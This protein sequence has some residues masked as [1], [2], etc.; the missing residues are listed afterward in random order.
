MARKIV[1]AMGWY[2]DITTFWDEE[3]DSA[4]LAI[5]GEMLQQGYIFSILQDGALQQ[6]ATTQ[7]ITDR[8]VVMP[9][10]SFSRAVQNGLMGLGGVR[11]VSDQ[12]V[13]GE[14]ARDAA[15]VLAHD[16]VATPPMKG[17]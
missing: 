9:T 5:I 14:I 10:D 17:G 16:T 1:L 7:Q 8:K 4:A 13:T 2:G 12:A 15:T 3:N 11:A 6:I